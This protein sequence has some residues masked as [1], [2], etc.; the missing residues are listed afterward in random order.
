MTND[1]KPTR[2]VLLDVIGERPGI[3]ESAI[4][5]VTGWSSSRITPSRIR[6]W[7]AG[8]IA[9]TTES[10]WENA[11]ANRPRH[12]GWKVVEAYQER[13]E[14][15][16]RA[17]TRPR[18]NAKSAEARARKIVDDLSDPVVDR[19]VRK[20]LKGTS[21]S[22]R[23]QRRVDQAV[24]QHQADR[25]RRG[26]QARRD[27]GANADS[28]QMLGSLWEARGAVA[29]IDAHLIE[30]RA[31]IANGE[32]R[33]I[34]D[35]DWV[36]AL[37]DVRMIIQSFGSMWQNVRDLGDPNEPCPACGA[38]QVGEDRHLKA[39]AMDGTVVED[40]TPAVDDAEIVA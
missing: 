19:L 25:I 28:Q 13:A 15:A 9:P 18:R 20:M 2:D 31:R 6:L 11:L 5:K 40:E 8:E 32:D 37:T 30:E 12:V 1:T 22:E 38:P 24:R 39:F 34:S 16:A 26:R 17:R 23:E 27:K 33:R 4:A 14:V 35:A 3:T 36:T 10:G 7:E 29:A 21:N